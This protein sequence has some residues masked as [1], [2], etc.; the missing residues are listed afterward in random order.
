MLAFSDPEK[1]CLSLIVSNCTYRNNYNDGDYIVYIYSPRA[2]A[3][4][5]SYERNLSNIGNRLDQAMFINTT[6]IDNRLNQNSY[7]GI[8]GIEYVFVSF[9]NCMF[10]NSV[11]SALQA[12]DSVVSLLSINRFVNNSGKLG[13]GLSLIRSRLHLNENSVTDFS[14]NKADYGGGLFA[15]P[16]NVEFMI[17]DKLVLYPL[18]RLSLKMYD[19]TKLK[20]TVYFANN[21]AQ[22][23]GHSVFYGPF[24]HCYVAPDCLIQKYK[25]NSHG[26]AFIRKSLANLFTFASRSVFELTTVPNSLLIYNV[27]GTD[28][29]KAAVYTYPGANFNV[30]FRTEGEYLAQTPVI[31]TATLCNNLS[32]TPCVNDFQSE[33]PYGADQQLATYECSNITYKVHS[34]RRKVFLEIRISRL[35]EKNFPVTFYEKRDVSAVVEINILPCPLGYHI[36]NQKPNCECDEYLL[37]LGVKCDI[38]KGG[39]VLRPKGLWIGYQSN[40]ISANKYCPFDYCIPTESFFSLSSPDDQCKNSRSGI[41]CGECQALFLEL[42]TVKNVPTCTFY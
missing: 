5:C 12:T 25:C 13:G 40:T 9:S 15:L 4:I 11:G 30:S 29:S 33:Y 1:P 6:F 22:S 34:L 20:L 2:S 10:S 28:S 21:T 24:S 36:L 32:L 16:D 42:Q 41:L 38:N 23:S 17:N 7:K 37:R 14:N 19:L 26:F 35:L 18:C 39:K 8:I 3:T 27:N 31:L